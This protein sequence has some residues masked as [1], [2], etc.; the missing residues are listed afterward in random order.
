LPRLTSF[1]VKISTDHYDDDALVAIV[2]QL[3]EMDAMRATVQGTQ[4]WGMV[5]VRVL[6]T[7]EFESKGDF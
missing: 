5:S 4:D 1:L 3:W 6:S 2:K 7:S